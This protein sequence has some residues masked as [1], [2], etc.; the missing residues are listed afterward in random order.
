MLHL[1]TGCM[2]TGIDFSGQTFLRVFL[3]SEV[4]NGRPLTPLSRL[5]AQMCIIGAGPVGCAVALALAARGLKVIS[6]E[7]RG[8]ARVVRYVLP[9]AAFTPARAAHRES[10]VRDAPSAHPSGR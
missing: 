5:D 7:A 9:E 6:I 1:E 4:I 2:M 8:L 3:R 10:A